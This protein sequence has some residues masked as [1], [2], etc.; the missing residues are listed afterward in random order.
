M[1]N[2]YLWA[3]PCLLLGACAGGS[4]GT[5]TAGTTGTGS[6][7]T[8]GT[9]GTSGAGNG[10]GTG[11]PFTFPQNKVSNKCTLTT[12]ANASADAMAAY[13]SWRTTYVTP[14]GAGSGLRVQRGSSQTQ[15]T[16][17]SAKTDNDT[18]SEGIGYGMVAAVYA[19]DRPT[20]DGL[21]TY[22]QAHFDSKGLM[23][24]HITSAGATA[25][26][27]TG[28]ATDG[29]EDMAWALL[30]ASDQW[31]S[32]TYLADAQAVIN[33]IFSNAIFSNGSLQN[34]DS[35]DGTDAMHTDYFSPAY[36]RVF[37]TATQ[38]GSWSGLVI[39]TNY[40]HLAALTGAHGLVPDSTNL[41]NSTSCASCVPNYGYDACRTPWRIALDYCFN[42][43]QRAL[44]Y[45]T[46][47]GT[48]FNGVSGGAANICDSYTSAGQQGSSCNK[49]S[50]FIGPA[51]VSGMAGF[52]TLLDGAFTFNVTNPSNSNNS[53]FAQ[54]LRVLTM[55]MMSGNFL[56]YTQG[57]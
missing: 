39:D 8:S 57:Q 41:E 48:F 52:Q 54:S 56:D 33:A 11:G 55:L 46:A 31:N 21:W 25:C 12:V 7:G 19:N 18:V 50:A 44:T 42:G 49:N 30:M 13:M 38:N 26:D 6:A 27:G 51:G 37:A 36:Y 43:E 24:W 34:G 9:A 20:L 22:A 32:T 3:M 29:D 47:I 23:N 4:S 14:T 15:P 2:R 35:W 1:F 53:Y 10:L 45:L 16:C 40:T 17:S 28:S 5:G